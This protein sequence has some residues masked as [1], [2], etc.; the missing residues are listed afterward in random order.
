LLTILLG[1]LL[2][3][4]YAEQ[5]YNHWTGEWETTSPD[6][7]MEYNHWTGEWGYHS[8]DLEYNHWSGKWEY[9]D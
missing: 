8:G 2:G 9:A 4:S 1:S 7:T 3:S 5:K 6:S